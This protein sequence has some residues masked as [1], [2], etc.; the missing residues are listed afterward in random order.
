VSRV[1]INPGLCHRGFSVRFDMR[2][3][4]SARTLPVCRLRCDR[5]KE[6]EVTVWA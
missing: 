2:F 4:Q 3:T 6:K 5:A 1:M